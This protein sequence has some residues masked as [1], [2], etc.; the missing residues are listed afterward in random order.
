[1]A[2]GPAISGVASGNTE[3][4]GLAV[5]SARSSAVVVVPPERAGEHHV[6]RDQQQQHAAGGA[7]GRQGDAERPQHALAEQGEEQ[8]DAGRRSGSPCAPWR[9]A[10]ARCSVA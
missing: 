8:Q 9:A 6:D 10:R 5:A 1:M 7:Q 3:M 4:S 2:P